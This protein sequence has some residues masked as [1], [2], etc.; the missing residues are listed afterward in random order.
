MS[1]SKNWNCTSCFSEFN[2]SFLKNSQVQINFKL[3]EKKSYDYL[4]IIQTWKNWHGKS[5]GICFLK[6]FFRIRENFFRSFCTKFLSLLYIISLAYKITPCLSANQNPELRCVICTG[7]TLFAP[8]LH[9]LHRCYTF[10][11][12][13]TLFCTGVTLELHCSQPIRIEYFFHMY[14]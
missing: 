5:A 12:G 4:L 11:T 10:C 9:F 7:V 8:V 6:P 2:F 1:F 14:Y 13:V 3:N